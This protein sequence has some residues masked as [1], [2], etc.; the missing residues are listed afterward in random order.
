MKKRA[1]LVGCPGGVTT[2]FLPGVEQDLINMQ[3]Y[4]QSNS[5]GNWMRNEITVLLN[6]TAFEVLQSLSFTSS[7]YDFVYFSGHGYTEFPSKRRMLVFPDVSISDTFLLNECGKQLIL[8]DACRDYHETLAGPAPKTKDATGVSG[9]LLRNLFDNAIASSSE[10]KLIIHAATEGFSSYDTPFGGQFTT[11]LLNL[12]SNNKSSDSIKLYSISS[13]LEDVKRQLENS[14]SIQ[15]PTIAY[16]EGFLNV[17]FSIAAP[18]DFFGRTN[19]N[20]FGKLVLLGLAL[21]GISKL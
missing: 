1:I 14:D 15:I 8:I 4:L 16:S 21:W 2:D 6:P 13:M 3:Y 12:A 9:D 17:P 5:G 10:G 19:N 20:E 7:Q 18:N 11:A